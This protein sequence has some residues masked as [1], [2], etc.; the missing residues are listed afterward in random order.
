M[1]SLRIRF[2]IA[3]ALVV[4][5]SAYASAA[6]SQRHLALVRS[7]P[8]ADST[9][10]AAPAALKLY[11]TQAP[12][13]AVT[14]IRLTG[15]GERAVE[16]QAAKADEGDAKIVVVPVSGQLTPGVYTVTWRT[17]GDDGHV[18]NGSY[19]FTYRADR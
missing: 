9:V 1:S 15:P 16:V 10:T 2:A 17:A 11:W 18:L 12:R 13:I 4:F 3:A 14:A 7:E 19:K 5:L 6:P 8:G